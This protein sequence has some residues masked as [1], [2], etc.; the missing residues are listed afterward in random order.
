MKPIFNF[1]FIGNKKSNDP[2]YMQALVFILV[3]TL[4]T[5]SIFIYNDWRS[6]R[7][8]KQTVLPK[9][10]LVE[11]IGTIAQL[12]EALTMSAYMATATGEKK[13]ELRYLLLEPKLDSAIQRAKRISPEFFLSEE[14]RKTDKANI[15]LV[16]MEKHSFELVHLG[17]SS[18]AKILLESQEYYSQKEAYASGFR[19]MQTYLNAREEEHLFLEHRKLLRSLL[20][21]LLMLPMLI[22][23]WLFVLRLIL[24]HE[25]ERNLAER[26]L[27]EKNDEIEAQ[28]E[29]YLQINEELK[30]KNEE[31]ATA[32]ELA[33]E[34][35]HDLLA[36]NQEYEAINEEL[37]QANQEL[38]IAKEKAEESDR[39][40]TIFLQ[41][42]SHE[43]RTP[44]N[45]IMGFSDL[46]DKYF[47]DKTKLQK[48][49]SIVRQ[50]SS[51]LLDLIN[52]ILDLSKIEAGQL[53]IYKEEFNLN[54]L[55]I[56]LHQFF[57]NQFQ[58]NDK[59]DIIFQFIP[60][61]DSKKIFICT[62]KGKLKQIFIN[63]IN[64]AF[65]FTE[66][67]SITFGC[68][69][70]LNSNLTFFV[71]DTGIGIPEDKQAVIFERFMQLNTGSSTLKGGTG[72]G[73]SIVKGL[74]KLLEGE[75]TLKSVANEGSTFSFSV[76]YQLT[77]P[78]NEKF[79][80]PTAQPEV[81][82]EAYNLLIVEDDDYNIEF[83]KELLSDT[84]IKIKIAMTGEQS[85]E[86]VESDQTIDII[87]MDI[88]MPGM[89]GYEATSIIKNKKPQIKVIAVTA[90]A[91]SNDRQTAIKAG[92]DDYISK[93]VSK[94]LLISKM[95]EQFIK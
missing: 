44:M 33:V 7:Y 39:L 88:R 67:G 72:L 50:R 9:S 59:R 48:F 31:L 38:H 27:N 25:L 45:A 19:K 84:G 12:D 32:K 49:T 36:K 87:L 83:L 76:S 71:S 63:L 58:K 92:C 51:D 28:N 70:D 41:N 55:F 15:A 35:K 16:K 65:K 94:E 43:I 42:M 18:Q 52:D 2:S 85:I 57:I 82:W 23:S 86:I 60:I 14:A 8:F 6:Y 40:K 30:E 20:L 11:L 13:W 93:P 90:Y 95:N 5:M 26:Y 34:S 62:D 73:L 81:R 79:K 74:I 46:F 54:E 53:P 4:A 47:D 10:R 17:L 56:E 64:N 68:I 75:I 89:N 24:K 66:K 80:K 29:E 1:L 3:I 21:T 78:R 77:E 69:K 61:D 22:I 91:T 37:M